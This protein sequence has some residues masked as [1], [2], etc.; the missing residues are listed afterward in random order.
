[1]LWPIIRE[2]GS[3]IEEKGIEVEASRLRRYPRLLFAN[4]VI[5]G[6]LV[7]RA[8]FGLVEGRAESL[9]EDVNLE[10]DDDPKKSIKEVSY[11]YKSAYT[12]LQLPNMT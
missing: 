9:S 2:S 12:H 4:A 6:D 10:D 3:A 5:V 7:V 11:I 1:M 8:T